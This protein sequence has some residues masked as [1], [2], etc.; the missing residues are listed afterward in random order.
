MKSNI[1]I[2]TKDFVREISVSQIGLI[3]IYIVL[4]ILLHSFALFLKSLMVLN[5][6]LNSNE[7]KK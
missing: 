4:V 7:C 2:V 6:F 1:K 5:Q 3:F